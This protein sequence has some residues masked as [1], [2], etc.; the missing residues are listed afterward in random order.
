MLRDA[1]PC[2][3]PL[4]GKKN[5]FQPS[6]EMFRGEVCSVTFSCSSCTSQ[7]GCSQKNC[8]AV[9]PEPFRVY[10]LLG[11][12]SLMVFNSP[13]GLFAECLKHTAQL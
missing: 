5:H 2:G 7:S 8:D 6:R 11:I 3:Q 10:S 9:C 1:K 12:T 13:G 4:L